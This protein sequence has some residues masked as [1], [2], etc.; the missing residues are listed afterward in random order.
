VRGLLANTSQGNN[1]ITTANGNVLTSP[2]SHEALYGQFAEG[3][4]VPAKESMLSACGRD[5]ERGV[6]KQ[7]FFAENLDP[8]LAAR[9]RAVCVKA[10]VQEGPLLDACTLDVTV[11]GSDIPAKVFATTPNPVLVGDAR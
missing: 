3:W 4:R 1:T 5:V 11:I 9:S 10:G 2:F 7:P 6:P 8:Q